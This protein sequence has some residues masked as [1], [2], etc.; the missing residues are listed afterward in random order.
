METL[1]ASAIWLRPPATMAEASAGICFLPG[2][3]RACF[4]VGPSSCKRSRVSEGHCEKKF[5]RPPLHM[6][7][8]NPSGCSKN[9]PHVEAPT[10][11][12]DLCACSVDRLW[13]PQVFRI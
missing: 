12:F 8:I 1:E 10:L 6:H 9:D 2:L 11:A 3:S 7:V 4:H 13:R 5:W